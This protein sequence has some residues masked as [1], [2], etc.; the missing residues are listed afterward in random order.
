LSAQVWR[1]AEPHRKK[2]VRSRTGELALLIEALA[3]TGKAINSALVQVGTLEHAPPL[4]G[5]IAR[6]L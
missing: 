4:S 6:Q 5:G 1:A 2:L 3:E